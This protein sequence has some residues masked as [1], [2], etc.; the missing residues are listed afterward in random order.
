MNYRARYGAHRF[1]YIRE[2]CR[3]ITDQQGLD[4]EH[5]RFDAPQHI[6]L[7]HENLLGIDRLD[8]RIARWNT[9]QPRAQKVTR[10]MFLSNARW[11]FRFN[12][13]LGPE[14]RQCWEGM[15]PWGEFV[16]TEAVMVEDGWIAD[17]MILNVVNEADHDVMVDKRLHGG[18]NKQCL[19]ILYISIADDIAR[20]VRLGVYHAVSFDCHRRSIS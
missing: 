10:E 7:I 6:T 4:H 19:L 8:A 14:D 5:Q 12:R 13:Y 16:K 17:Y 11:A 2:V 15:L 20:S 3:L 1:F 18:S 9:E